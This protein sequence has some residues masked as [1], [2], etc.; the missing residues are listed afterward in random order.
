MSRFAAGVALAAT[1]LLAGGVAW[2]VMYGPSMGQ[3]GDISRTGS[4]VKNQR[5][6]SGENK[7]PQSSGELSGQKPDVP[8]SGSSVGAMGGSG[9]TPT[10]LVAAL[11]TAIEARN[12][13]AVKS[14]VRELKLQSAK[15]DGKVVIAALCAAISDAPAE[16]EQ[17]L[18]RLLGQ[19][20]NSAALEVLLDLVSTQEVRYADIRPAAFSA[21][22]ESAGGRQDD[23]SFKT[24]LSPLLVT[25]LGKAADDP[26][27]LGELAHSIAA[28]GSAE[29]V[30]ALLT[31]LDQFSADSEQYRRVAAS[32]ENIAN[33]AA[34][35]P[36]TT[37]L[38]DDAILAK[39]TTRISGTA[40]AG[41]GQPEATG[42]LLDW[43]T[44][45]E[46]PTARRQA[47]E[48]L[49]QAADERSIHMLGQA[50]LRSDF[51]DRKLAVEI[52]KTAHALKQSSSSDD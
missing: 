10:Q 14:A 37:R 5:P 25:Q 49:G 2:L 18:V 35:P 46:S 29:G 26:R 51:K 52:A 32:M 12:D 27:Q 13:V 39:E 22:R 40:F 41:M 3:P 6:V 11:V 43:A 9:V 16:A 38:K 31:Q 44:G 23:G 30:S 20:G 33:P 34:V 15:A 47:L 17:Y 28:I 4:P 50:A 7:P 19:I 1:T 42:A 45:L 48:W 24:E 36:L 8:A 21:I